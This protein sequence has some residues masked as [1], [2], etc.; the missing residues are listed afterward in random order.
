[1]R[2]DSESADSAPGVP[3]RRRLYQPPT[4]FVASAASGMSDDA[5]TMRVA[6]AY[7]MVLGML[8]LL[9]KMSLSSKRADPMVVRPLSGSSLAMTTSHKRRHPDPSV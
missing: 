4:V 1:M 6:I 3:S 9:S 7:L 5:A 2:P 8:V